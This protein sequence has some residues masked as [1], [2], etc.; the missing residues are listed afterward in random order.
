MGRLGRDPELFKYVKGEVS[1]KMYT[2]ARG[3]LVELDPMENPYLQWI[4][5]GQCKYALPTY[6]REE[7]YEKVRN[8]LYKLELVNSSIEDYLLDNDTLFNAFN[9][10]DIFEYLSDEG[11]Q[12]LY[13]KIIE[14]SQP[15]A[16]L[17]YW[18]LFVDRSRPVNL[19]SRAKRLIDES[20]ELHKKDRAFFYSAFVLEERC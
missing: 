1:P 6:L 11:F 19:A 4:L 7:N 14:R 2:R 17:A 5:L 8:N 3:A 12:H 20:L 10:S 13:E 16:R 15:G 9:L 18:N